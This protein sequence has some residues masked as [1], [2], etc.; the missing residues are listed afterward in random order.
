MTVTPWPYGAYPNAPDYSTHAQQFAD[1]TRLMGAPPQFQVLYLWEGEP[2]WNWPNNAGWYAG[3][4]RASAARDTVPIIGFPL[5]SVHGD[6]GSPLDQMRA[7]AAGQHDDV[8][9][10]VVDTYAAHGCQHQIWRIGWEMNLQ[11]T[12]WFVG[13][14]PE[15]WE[16]WKAAFRRVATVMHE[17]SGGS[18]IQLE[19]AWNPGATSW[20]NAGR[21][22]LTLYPGD[23][24]VD[25]IAIDVYNQLW[26]KG[27]DHPFDW[28]L[29]QPVPKS[30]WIKNPA[31]RRHHWRYPGADQW[32]H[33]GEDDHAFGLDLALNLAKQHG[34]PFGLAETGVFNIDDDTSVPD[35]AEF[36]PTIAGILAEGIAPVAWV[37]IWDAGAGGHDAGWSSPQ[38]SMPRTQQAW[39]E[40]FGARVAEKPEEPPKPDEP[41]EPDE[42]TIVGTF[43]G[44]FTGTIMPKQ[45]R[46]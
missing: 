32:N 11:D 25:V 8:I 46:R 1:I 17:H 18:G 44:T 29:G 38:T 26:P 37:V 19:T 16:V 33:T 9:R 43:T 30:E 4:F 40:A 10:A 7:F 24:V 15:H 6:A 2:I 35:D 34:K 41:D 39:V 3:L 23:D 5:F 31:N 13:D 28:T 20:S 45:S 12:P 36:P 21:A 42:V 27:G 22:D 14:T